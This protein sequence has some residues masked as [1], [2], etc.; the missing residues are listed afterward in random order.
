MRAHAQIPTH[1]RRYRPG[2]PV[3]AIGRRACHPPEDIADVLERTSVEVGA[4][5]LA[6]DAMEELA[7]RLE[8]ASIEGGAIALSEDAVEEIADSL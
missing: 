3:L 1:P 7:D 6:E 5:A 4:I 8:R 2:P